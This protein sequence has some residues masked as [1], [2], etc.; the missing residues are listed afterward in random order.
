MIINI[1]DSENMHQKLDILHIT[2]YDIHTLIGGIQKYVEELANLQ[3]INNNVTIFSCSNT[4]KGIYKHESIIH[5]RFGYFE[6]FRTPISIS[7]IIKFIRT[8]C[9]IVHIHAQFPITGELIALIARL[10]RI[11]VI[12]SYHNEPHIFNSSLFTR[13]A[14]KIWR[15][16]LFN[17]LLYC[18]SSIIV[19]TEDYLN[20]SLLHGRY[21]LRDKIH[22]IPCGIHV[23]KFHNYHIKN[24]NDDNIILYVGRIKPEK[25]IHVLIESIY[26]LKQKGISTKLFIV[27][28]SSRK[29]EKMYKQDL[30]ML[31]NKFGIKDHIVFTGKV[32]DEELNKLYKNATVL[33]LPSL[34][35]LE[36]F[37]IVQ[38]EAMANGLPIIVTDLPGPRA[39]S[40][41]SSIV[42]KP[43]DAYEL[44]NAISSLISNKTLWEELSTNAV[45]NALRYDW[46]II[47]KEVMSV[48]NKVL[49]SI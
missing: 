35:R 1:N 29:D 47:Y 40:L 14:Y 21:H 20:N 33:V 19:T 9:D 6:L 42:V 2:Q 13:I 38:L 36:G 30:E 3:S 46:K 32:S 43:N 31:I 25:G 34:N 23:S 16:V 41:E 49:E 37:G 10:R 39:V 45:K 5:K 7:M 18:S 44:C 11:P 12:V 28:D 17:I 26:L 8:K 48:Y 22:I 15:K 24:R 4:L 27:G